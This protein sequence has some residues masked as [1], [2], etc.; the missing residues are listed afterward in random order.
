MKKIYLTLLSVIF[1][2][3]GQVFAQTTVT[4]NYTGAMQT[5]VVPPCVTQITVSLL[6]GGGGTGGET[7]NS[8]QDIG[9]F[10]GE[11]IGVL[12]VVT[13]TTLDIF[14]G[15]AG[16]IGTSAGGGIGGWNGGGDAS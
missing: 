7:S 5:W 11:V 8:S 3:C 16:A 2:Y 13:G 12:P 14:V 10:G 1:F 6:G 9:G 4:F 15:G